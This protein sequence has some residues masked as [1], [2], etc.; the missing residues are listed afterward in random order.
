M[1]TVWTQIETEYVLV[2]PTLPQFPR[3]VWKHPPGEG[4]CGNVGS[5]KNCTIPIW[6]HNVLL[7]K[8]TKLYEF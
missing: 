6:I 7:S 5:I 1:S 3:P 2:K 8:Q 4:N